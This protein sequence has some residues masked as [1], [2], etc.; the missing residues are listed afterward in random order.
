MMRRLLTDV[1]V[2][3]LVITFL[4]FLRHTS[5]DELAIAGRGEHTALRRALDKPWMEKLTDEEREAL[6]AEGARVLEKQAER[7]ASDD[8]LAQG[9]GNSR[10]KV[11]VEPLRK[12]DLDKVIAKAE[13]VEADDG[14]PPPAEPEVVYATAFV[15]FDGKQNI[16][17]VE[18]EL[19]EGVNKEKE[20]FPPFSFDP[21]VGDT[22]FSDS[23]VEYRVYKRSF[24]WAGKPLK[25]RC[26][27]KIF[28][29]VVAKSKE[30]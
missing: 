19:E 15:A 7:R 27:F 2:V 13:A 10:I 24:G 30:A 11:S 6:Y 9:Q 3:I 21:V 17:R 14:P 25:S 20:D 29:L 5:G 12:K 26:E 22:V 28:L 1:S 8:R 16:I 4:A 18:Y 23:G